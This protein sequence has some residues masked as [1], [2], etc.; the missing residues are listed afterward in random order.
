MHLPSLD[1]PLQIKNPFRKDTK[2][3]K[4]GMYHPGRSNSYRK[5]RISEKMINF[6]VNSLAL[7]Q[8]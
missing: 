5:D 7:L 2:G 6:I 4:K 1:L 3:A 8:F